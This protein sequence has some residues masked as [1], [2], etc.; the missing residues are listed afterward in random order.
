MPKTKEFE[1]A[2][3]RNLALSMKSLRNIHTFNLAISFQEYSKSTIRKPDKN[4]WK[5]IDNV[6]SFQ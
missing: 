1:I 4:T 6:L 2:V 3:E 5:D